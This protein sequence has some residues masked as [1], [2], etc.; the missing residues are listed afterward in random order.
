MKTKP[1]QTQLEASTHA[2]LAA[3]HLYRASQVHHDTSLP[4]WD[5]EDAKDMRV[6]ARYV[7]HGAIKRMSHAARLAVCERIAVIL[8]TAN[9]DIWPECDNQIHRGLSDDRRQA[10][11]AMRRQR[12]RH[13]AQLVCAEVARFYEIDIDTPAM[14]QAIN[15]QAKQQVEADKRLIAEYRGRIGTGEVV[16]ITGVRE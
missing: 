6:E 2:E 1:V 5:S 4:S 14:L 15:E 3:F 16:A 8:A 9:G 11:A 7:A 12:Y 13:H 10:L